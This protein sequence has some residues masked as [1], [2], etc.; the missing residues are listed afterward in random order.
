M[1]TSFKR[2]FAK[3]LRKIPEQKREK[4]EEFIF[5]TAPHAESTQDLAP[6]VALSGHAGFYRKRFGD[7][8]VGFEVSEGKLIFYRAL[9]RK[10]IYKRFP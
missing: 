7:Y 8:R 10:E 2:A 3:D 5:E 1:E 9:H 4:I 6:V